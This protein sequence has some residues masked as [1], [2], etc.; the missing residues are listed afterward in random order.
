M[1]KVKITTDASKKE[2]KNREQFLKIFK[3]C[4]IPDNE[5]LVNIGL[6]LKRQDLT[7]VLFFNE[8]Y[9]KIINIHGIII[10]FGCRWGQNLVTLSNLRGIYEPYNRNR[11]IV[12]FDTF[13]G[14]PNVNVKDGNAEII[15]KNAMSCTDNYDEYLKKIL[16]YHEKESPLAHIKKNFVKI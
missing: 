3:N 5:I 15:E 4:S 2:L 7:K 16:D 12:G 11:K 1:K 6:F 10:E 8:I 9:K 13:Q 14:F